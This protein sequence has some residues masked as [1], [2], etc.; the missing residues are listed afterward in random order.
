MAQLNEMDLSAPKPP[1]KPM[2]LQEIT[3]ST[4]SSTKKPAIITYTT[5][6]K[7]IPLSICGETNSC[8]K[9]LLTH[10]T[11]K[12]AVT[13]EPIALYEIEAIRH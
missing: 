9:C 6:E 1:P 7:V 13:N 11:I 3:A 12:T 4:V 8:C 2:A 10:K 5:A